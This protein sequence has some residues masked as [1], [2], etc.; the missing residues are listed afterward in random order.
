MWAIGNPGVTQNDICINGLI[1]NV[2]VNKNLIKARVQL[3]MYNAI[4]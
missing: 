2:Y 4:P 1:N 3:A